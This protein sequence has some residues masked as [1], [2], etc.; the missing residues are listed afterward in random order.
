[1][2]R[3]G[4][5]ASPEGLAHSEW[6]R[7]L[8]VLLARPAQPHQRQIQRSLAMR[9]KA[10]VTRGASAALHGAHRLHCHSCAPARRWPGRPALSARPV[11]TTTPSGRQVR[12]S[13]R[14]GGRAH[15]FA[16]RSR[17]A[18]T[19]VPTDL[20]LGEHPALL[21]RLRHQVLNLLHRRAALSAAEN[22]ACARELSQS[23][24]A[25]TWWKDGLCL[26]AKKR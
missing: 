20:E 12:F 7:G 18:H 15:A 23:P 8:S 11:S 21:Q 3:M 5:T 2:P 14:S 25:T 13:A 6:R 24:V 26:P 19:P 4:P 16:A 17:R 1:M 9:W 10:R 22:P